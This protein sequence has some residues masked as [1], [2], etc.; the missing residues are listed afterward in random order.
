MFCLHFLNE[1]EDFSFPGRYIC[2]ICKQEEWEKM[3][4]STFENC[5]LPATDE[6]ILGM[7]TWQAQE[8]L[9]FINPFL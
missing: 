8:F 6:S 5:W 7:K 1:V 3:Y 4:L 2:N 9:C